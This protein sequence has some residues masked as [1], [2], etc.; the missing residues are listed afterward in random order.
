MNEGILGLTVA[1]IGLI[2][3]LL[4]AY[5]AGRQQIRLEQQKWR[6]AR[7]DELDK[8]KRLAVAELCRTLV[9]M[10]Q[11]GQGL[12]W[13]ATHQPSYINDER[14]KEYERITE[15]LWPE[16]A[17]SRV[18]VAALDSDIYASI[19][20]LFLKTTRLDERMYIALIQLENSRDESIK[21]MAELFPEFSS[22]WGELDQTVV[23]L[24]GST[25]EPRQNS[26]KDQMK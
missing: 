12:A 1:L 19:N 21:A 17:S 2:A 22:F 16:I 7:Q 8:E 18:I 15:Q 13:Y 5:V 9:T 6:A 25:S 23:N 24:F 20:P 10:V 11:A 26:G 3:G 4:G 14:A